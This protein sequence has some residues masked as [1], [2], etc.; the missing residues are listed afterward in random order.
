[1]PNLIL[2]I[3]S[4]LV[5]AG[6]FFAVRGWLRRRRLVK[7]YGAEAVGRPKIHWRERL[8]VALIL[9]GLLCMV[10]AF[11]QTHVTRQATHGT[12]IL[13]MDTSHSMT[14]D[15]IA[16]TRLAAART[17]ARAFLDELPE[18]FDVGVVT[19]AGRPSVLIPPTADRVAVSTALADLP[20]TKGTVIGDGLNTALDSIADRWD[21]QGVGPAAVL[22]LS[23]GQDTGSDV[24]PTQAAERAQRMGIPVYTV[25]LGKSDSDAKG[26]ADPILLAQMADATGGKAFTADTANGL[27][28]VYEEFGSTLSVDLA[29]PGSA[30]LWVVL[31]VAMVLA[32]GFVL[33]M[34]S[35]GH[36]RRPRSRARPRVAGTR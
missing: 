16:P 30:T 33:L 4:V 3:A 17:A 19:F 5:L 11:T 13:T 24:T 35:E 27:T 10:M 21:A 20:V 7:R 26:M 34:P 31:A 14:E 32:A 25:T 8:P 23:D 2:P 12:V 1:M 28:Q 29:I 6:G 15:D 18:G 36:R 9:G 22:L